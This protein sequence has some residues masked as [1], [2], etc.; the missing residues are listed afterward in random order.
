VKDSIFLQRLGRQYPVPLIALDYYGTYAHTKKDEEGLTEVVVFIVE[1]LCGVKEPTEKDYT[2]LV[3]RLKEAEDKASSAKEAADHIPQGKKSFGHALN[4]WLEGTEA[5]QMFS[6]MTNYNMAEVENLYCKIDFSEAQ[7]LLKGYV[8]SIQAQ[9]L[10]DYECA[11]Y[12]AGGHYEGDKKSN[13]N[14][15]QYDANSKEGMAALQG[16]GFGNINLGALGVDII[17]E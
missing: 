4:T 1:T 13:S 6:K 14:V 15:K 11:L 16:F 3:S 2:Y 7:E 12:A 10:I 9:A 8:E 5:I 17:T